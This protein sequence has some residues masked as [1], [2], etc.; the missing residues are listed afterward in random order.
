MFLKINPKFADRSNVL[1]SK[2]LFTAN[3][4]TQDSTNTTKSSKVLLF[5]TISGDRASLDLLHPVLRSRSVELSP[6]DRFKT[7]NVI[8]PSSIN[9]RWSHL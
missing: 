8:F 6:S 7:A 9:V 2:S 4:C 1:L 3:P 5:Y